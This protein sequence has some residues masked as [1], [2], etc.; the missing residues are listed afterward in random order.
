MRRS[1][2]R[3]SRPS[4]SFSCLGGLLARMTCDPRCGLSTRTLKSM[5]RAGGGNRTHTDLLGPSDFLSFATSVSHLCSSAVCPKLCPDLTGSFL[6]K[7]AYNRKDTD[8]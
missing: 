2:H 1:T 6:P 5:E 3:L 8:I 4:C 7:Y